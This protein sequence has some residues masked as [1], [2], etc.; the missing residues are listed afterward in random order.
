MMKRR[1]GCVLLAL[2]AALLLAAGCQKG[3]GELTLYGVNTG[4]ADCLLF[5]LPNGE[6]LLVDTGLKDTYSQIKAVLELAGV[7]KI[8][9][10]IITHGHKD[11]I[12][13]LKQLAKDY[14]IGTIYTNDYDTA[15]Y[16]KKERELLST[17]A[18]KWLPLYPATINGA[19]RSGTSLSF[20][21][22]AVDFLAP[23]RPYS[24]EEDDNNNSLV[25]RLTHG[26][27]SFLLMA[28]ATSLIEEDLLAS[29]SPAGLRAD[30]LK[31]GRHG[32]ADAN[33][34]AFIEAVAPE[35]VYLTGNRAQDADSPD[36][37][38]LARY[39][40]IGAQAYINEGDQLAIVWVSDGAALSTGEYISAD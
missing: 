29:Y 39:A 21:N 22:I 40:A 24:D 14:K 37:A 16:G 27:V 19:S 15:T 13:G 38:V 9:H 32:Q 8:D 28:D 31:A 23:A 11:H 1:M 18:D 10:L 20:G 17:A 26:E 4:K 6:S 36:E 30:F 34:E 33:T 35:A 3:P 5:C 2:L 7:R 12:G 25:F